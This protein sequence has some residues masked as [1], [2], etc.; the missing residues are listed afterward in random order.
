MSRPGPGAELDALIEEFHALGMREL[1]LHL[2]GFELYLSSD[3]SAA[4]LGEGPQQPGAPRAASSQASATARASAPPLPPGTPPQA[5]AQSTPVAWPAG[6][7]VVVAP[8]MGMFYRSPKPGSPPY[9]E[10]GAEVT[11]QSELCLVEVMK[12][13]TAVR[14]GASGV[15]HAILAKD[16]QMVQAKQPLFV[17]T[18]RP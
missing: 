3:A 14:S 11:D 10:L 1:H 8:Y 6:A 4:G 13:F 16:G 18:P 2:E 17:I 9:V 12:L 15:V 5:G 7:T